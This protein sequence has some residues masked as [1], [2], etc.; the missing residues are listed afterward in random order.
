MSNLITKVKNFIKS[1][2]PKTKIA[3][4][5]ILV[6]LAVIFSQ[7]TLPANIAASGPKFNF[8]PGD[9]ELLRGANSSKGETSW[10]DPVTAAT[11][12]T[13][14]VLAYY[15]NGVLDT[16]AHNT[17]IRVQLPTSPST[18]LI[19]NGYLTADN[20]AQITDTFTVNTNENSTL[21]YI[22]GSTNWYPNGSQT[23][24]HLADGITTTGVNLGDIQG[25]WQFSGY[26]IFQVKIKGPGIPNI[27]IDKK[28]AN[29]T[30]ESGSQNWVDQ[31]TADPGDTLAYRLYFANSGT[32]TAENVIV[33]DNLPAYV[34]YMSG[35][36]K[37]YTNATGTGGQILPDAIT[38]T[39]ISLGNI[40]P[41][42]ENSGYIV[43]K[44]KIDPNLAPGCYSLVNL[45][46]ISS[47]NAG[48]K[49]DEAETLVCKGEITPPGHVTPPVVRVA[50]AKALPPT[51]NMGL[52]AF[53]LA[54][55]IVTMY[56]FLK[57]R[58]DF[59]A[60][61]IKSRKIQKLI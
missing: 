24:T 46:I 59:H 6:L 3:R 40:E 49:Q 17:K 19:L 41:G 58:K 51:G 10:H 56:Y 9:Y 57:V 61:Y 60:E 2:N 13:I 11:N 8:Q 39:G 42:A 47:D 45:A 31:N 43:F 35:T 16:V 37:L 7:I 12:D 54:S 34:S 29:S 18:I 4:F 14:S 30:K 27:T 44:V 23:P 48:S 20:A 22:L 53:I 32:A 25:C 21:E 50:G 5:S 36:A 33:K 1:K 38:T 26:V 55:V 28:V 15:H 52:I